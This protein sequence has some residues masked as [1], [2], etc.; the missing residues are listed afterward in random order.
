MSQLSRRQLLK[1]L[2]AGGVASAGMAC[3][4]GFASRVFAQATGMQGK[5]VITK[6]EPVNLHTY[7]ASEGSLLVTS[8][9][10]ETENSLLIVDTQFLQT[11]AREFRAYADSLG[12]SID[13]VILSHQHPDHWFGANQFTDV[14]FVS[15]TAIAEGAQATLDSGIIEFQTGIYGESEVPS[16]ANLPEG[17]LEAGEE[18]IDGVTIA[19][20]IYNDAEAPEHLVLRLPEARTVIVQDLVYNNAHFFPLGN[21]PNWIATLEEMRSLAGEGYDTLLA[22][23][24]VPTSLGDLDEAIDYLTFLEETLQ[25]AETPEEVVSAMQARY[26]T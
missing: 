14:P 2:A 8:H 23:H 1:L 6:A 20:D 19:F 7:I 10:V 15:T 25:D 21:N 9:I 4:P 24:G 17:G 16:E 3:V 26:P 11:F 13:R 12:K 18:T 22:G 5:V